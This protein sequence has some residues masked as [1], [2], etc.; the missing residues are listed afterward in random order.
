MEL[1]YNILIFRIGL[2]SHGNYWQIYIKD[3]SFNNILIYDTREVMLTDNN[4]KLFFKHR[5]LH[6]L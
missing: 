2:I 4:A 1:S 3:H 6:K 5:V